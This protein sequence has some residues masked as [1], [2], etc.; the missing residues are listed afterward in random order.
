[1]TIPNTDA[2]ANHAE[3]IAFLSRPET[4]GDGTDE[5]DVITTH[6]ARVF[7][8][9]TNAFKIKQP[10][11]YDYMD[12]ST[13]E[14]RKA[15]CEREVTVNRLFAPDLYRGVAAITREADGR[16]ALNGAG[17]PMEWAVHMDRFPEAAV[18]ERIAEEGA[19]DDVLARD[20]G[21]RIA[22]AHQ[23]L[24]P[25][26]TDDGARRIEEVI[27]ELAREFA[28]LGD[29][30]DEKAGDAVIAGAREWLR[31]TA[32]MLDR[33]A[34][35]GFVRRCHGDLHLRNIVLIDGLPTPFDALE[36]DERLG[37][38]DVLYDLAFLLMD[39]IHREMPS[40]ANT[41][42]NRYAYAAWA[43]FLP[44]GFRI[45]TLFLAIRA[46]IR[47]MVEA[48]TA[49]RDV[50]KGAAH[51]TEADRYLSDAL[52]FLAAE[53]PV[54]IGVGGLSGTGKSTLAARLVPG[55]PGPFGAVHLR[56]DLERKALFGAAE[57]DRLDERFYDAAS[58]D[59]VYE[60][61]LEKS[62]QALAQGQSVLVDAVHARAEERS[63]L[64]DL[65]ARYGAAFVGLWLEAPAQTLSARVRERVRDA[66]DADQSV[67]EKQLSA[68]SEAAPTPAETW[69]AV[70]ASGEPAET[71]ARAKD[72][73]ASRWR[74]P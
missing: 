68:F 55:L 67:L 13:L 16:L 37:T 40:A 54:L 19:F 31:E 64:A 3:V 8:G 23:R 14:K 36:F 52:G 5:V 32:D 56:S 46:A 65:A 27:E 53:P 66:S 1:M 41:V 9:R 58:S 63:A 17:D 43:H 6:G 26:D 28:S 38:T 21:R 24:R 7:L 12:F 69:Q 2:E 10:V 45:M 73:M 61:L 11:A 71:Q 50:E 30:L 20:V 49:L 18:L 72:I 57:F 35:L 47:A 70:N 4:F 34:A 33:R 22:E 15:V 51:R 39:L 25:A 59:K 48:Q 29:G 42:L 60:R 74:L 44:G 62:G